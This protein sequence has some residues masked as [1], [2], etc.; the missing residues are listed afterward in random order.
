MPVRLGRKTATMLE[1]RKLAP[2][3]LISFRFPN[4]AASL[5]CCVKHAQPR[6]DISPAGGISLPVASTT[7][8]VMVPVADATGKDVSP[9][10]LVLGRQLMQ[11]CGPWAIANSNGEDSVSGDNTAS[12]IRFVSTDELGCGK[13]SG[14]LM[15]VNAE[16]PSMRIAP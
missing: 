2:K 13:C 6:R 14:S 5:A 8:L 16:G 1:P 12:Y 7:G 15:A 9:S 3:V 4:Y 11:T 10:G